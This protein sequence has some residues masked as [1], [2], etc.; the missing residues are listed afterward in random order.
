MVE[1]YALCLFLAAIPLD[2]F[3]TMGMTILKLVGGVALA[4]WLL[5]RLRSRDPIRWDLGATLMLLFVFWGAAS[6]FWSIEPASTLYSLQTYMLLLVLYFLIVNVVRGEKQ[7]SPAMIALW[8][9]MLVLVISGLLGVSSI[10]LNDE[11]SRLAGIAGNPNTYV[12]ILVAL[13]PPSYWVYSRT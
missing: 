8:V 9:G 7:F 11:D 10:R 12:A 5:S 1:T 3:S 2:Q 13:V 4:G 6:Y